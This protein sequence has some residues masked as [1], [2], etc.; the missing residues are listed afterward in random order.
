MN[1]LNKICKQILNSRSD[2]KHPALMMHVVLGYPSLEKS[3]EIVKEMAR[4]G[5][6]IIELQIP[7]SDPI[8]DGA[9]IMAANEKALEEGVTPK[10]CLE[11]AKKL[12]SDVD[13]PLLFMSYFN[14]PFH[15]PGSLE[16]F[17]SDAK[18][19]GISGLI[20]PDVPIEERV[21]GYLEISKEENLIPIPIVS[22]VTDEKRLEKIANMTKDGFVYCTSTMGTTGAR[23]E[24]APGLK[25]Y[26]QGVREK[27]SVPIA[28]GFGI[29]S[30]EQ[31]KSLTGLA[32]IAVVGSATIDLISKGASVGEIRDFVG[33]LASS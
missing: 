2:S 30:V 15:Y 7:F 10:D 5:A 25:N 26:L 14:I 18:N 29:S 6:A 11:A 17:C 19:S 20:I 1:R 23:A 24:L 21:D 13:V 3:I 28:V 22:P 32:D 33:D 4:A 8:A 31:V 16:S 12:A 9:T 27:F